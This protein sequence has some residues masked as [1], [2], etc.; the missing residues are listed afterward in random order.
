MSVPERVRM[1]RD[2]MSSVMRG[3]PQQASLRDGSCSIEPALMAALQGRGGSPILVGAAKP[4]RPVPSHPVPSPGLAD[5]APCEGAGGRS[6]RCRAAPAG[7][8]PSVPRGHQPNGSAEDAPATGGRARG[9]SGPRDSD[10]GGGCRGA[11]RGLG[12][13]QSQEGRDV[14]THMHFLGPAVFTATTQD[15]S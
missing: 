2:C 4:P 8:Q 11:K 10:S 12:A 5:T 14:A 13:R 15:G 3:T 7:C 9:C 6:E 1:A